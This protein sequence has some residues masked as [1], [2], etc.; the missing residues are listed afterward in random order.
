MANE[1]LSAKLS[2]LD[3]RFSRL[4]SRIQ[5]SQ[6]ASRTRLCGEIKT[7]QKEYTQAEWALRR[8]LQMSKSGLVSVLFEEYQDIEDS[9]LAAESRLKARTSGSSD[10]AAEAKLLLAEY[11]LDFV[12]QAA[13][14][15]L[16][17]A[18]DAIATELLRQEKEER[19]SI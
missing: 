11:A 17:L 9:I 12:L 5:V 15:A 8:K 6:T 10:T 19:S 1:V 14:R 3:D 2:Q 16:L 13:D 4:H 7:L 18:L